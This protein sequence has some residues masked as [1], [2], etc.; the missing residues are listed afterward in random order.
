LYSENLVSISW[1]IIKNAITKIRLLAHFLENKETALSIGNELDEIQ[2][3]IESSLA[4]SEGHLTK[5]KKNHFDI[6]QF[7]DAFVRNFHGKGFDFE[8]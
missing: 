5:N 6:K 2:M 3:I 4:F 7:V 8:Y 1:S